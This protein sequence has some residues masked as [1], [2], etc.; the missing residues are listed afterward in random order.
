MHS[1]N[2]D[3]QD[4]RRSIFD[5]PDS[6]SQAG[7][8]QA[9]DDQTATR[10]DEEDISYKDVQNNWTAE[11]ENDL[12]TLSQAAIRNGIPSE[13][14]STLLD[15]SISLQPEEV[16]ND[17][18]SMTQQAADM[19][20]DIY[21]DV[22]NRTVSLNKQKEIDKMELQAIT[23][24][25]ARLVSE[26]FAINESEALQH[27]Q[28]SNYEHLMGS[29]E[30]HKER[31]KIDTQSV[32]R[33]YG[34]LAQ[35]KEDREEAKQSLIDTVTN[36]VM[37]ALLPVMILRLLVDGISM[38]IS[39]QKESSI[40]K[41]ITAAKERRVA[42]VVSAEKEQLNEMF[43]VLGVNVPNRKM[44]SL[45]PTAKGL[46]NN[47]SKI[48]HSYQALTNKMPKKTVQS[49]RTLNVRRAPRVADSPQGQAVI[50]K[51]TGRYVDKQQATTQNRGS[52]GRG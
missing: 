9:G 36:P 35:A 3:G 14:I 47:M 15:Q 19:N 20:L 5:E 39:E 17:V 48:A 40:E 8:G 31:S 12:Q 13:L 41:N 34:H 46:N 11:Q 21:Q 24:E 6:D 43:D 27:I 49:N 33:L 23:N 32:K 37:W 10:Y 2:D 52:S 18:A 22:F 1:R 42:N 45:N 38:A 7:D 29:Q 30:L 4:I 44:S 26:N 16:L 50:G 28:D 25:T 51:H